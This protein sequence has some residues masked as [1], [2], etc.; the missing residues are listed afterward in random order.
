MTATLA[1]HVPAIASVTDIV[2]P[3]Q[4]HLSEDVSRCQFF[5][6]VPVVCAP[7]LNRE[8]SDNNVKIRFKEWRGSC[9]RESTPRPSAQAR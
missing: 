8:T 4:M 2:C 5:D 9:N 3:I 6:K 7:D 1:P